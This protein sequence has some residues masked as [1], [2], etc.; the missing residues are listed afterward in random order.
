MVRKTWITRQCRNTEC[1]WPWPWHKNASQ[2]M[3]GCKIACII[4]YN[5]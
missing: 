1:T 2:K 5:H 4:H 3:L